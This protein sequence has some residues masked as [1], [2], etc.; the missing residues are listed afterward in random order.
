N[1]IY[2]MQFQ[3]YALVAG[4]QTAVGT[5]VESLGVTVNDGSFTVVL[6]FSHVR[7][8]FT[9]FDRFLG[10]SVKPE[11]SASYT[12]LL[13]TQKFTSTPYAI[14]SQNSGNASTATNATQ[15]GGVEAS[16]YVVTGDSR[17]SDARQPLP[18]SADYIQNS[19]L[20]QS[21]SNFNISCDGTA[22]GTLSANIVSATA[23]FNL[24]ATRVLSFRGTNNT[25][26]GEGAGGSVLSSGTNN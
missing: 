13:P 10:I 18:G 25:L 26:V 20:A 12:A 14:R 22:G 24:G 7:G 3:L 11:G 23:G 17:M 16:Q 8:T 19:I 6:D 4:S 9:G 5:P 21:S 1:G 2:D 15:L